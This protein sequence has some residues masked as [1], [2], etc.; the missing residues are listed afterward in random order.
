[1][2]FVLTIILML[3]AGLASA[4]PYP[5]YQSLG[6][7]DFA[8][9]LTAAEVKSLDAKLGDLRDKTGIEFTVLTLPSRSDYDPSPTLESFATRLF[10][11]WG[12]GN[13]ERNDGILLM[14]L[15]Q[16]REVR[17]ELGSGYSPEYDIPAQDIIRTAILPAFRDGDLP[18]GIAAGSDEII[19]RIADRW[20]QGLPPTATAKSSEGLFDT[21]LRY[22][23][24]LF[25]GAAAVLILLG[26][27]LR[28]RFKRCPNCGHRGLD[29]SRE[30]TTPAT[31]TTTGQGVWISRCPQCGWTG[32]ESFTTPARGRSSGGSF[33]GGRSSGGGASGRW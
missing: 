29:T 32:R 27:R 10:N 14:V 28:G 22:V 8:K 15:V 3:W 20:A 16:D 2:R 19:S 25:F 21:I 9:V 33:G 26:Q 6:V 12:I 31:R 13:A 17:I 1:M 23:V 24:Y 30:V 7:N 11:G 18:G 4:E 5:A